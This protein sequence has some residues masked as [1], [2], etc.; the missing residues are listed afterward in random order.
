MNPVTQVW[1]LLNRRHDVR[2]KVTREISGELDARQSSCSHGAKQTTKG[3]CSR[4]SFEAAVNSWSIAV[5]V[6]TNKMDLFVTKRLES[7][8]FSHDF[9]G[10][11]TPF[12]TTRVWNDTKRAELVAALDDWNKGDVW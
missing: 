7:Y 1:V 3:C 9:A 5:H 2:M 8:Y 10:R 6:L 11:S 12:T 4:K